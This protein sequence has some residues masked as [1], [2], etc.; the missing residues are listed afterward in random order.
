MYTIQH[1]A[2]LKHMKHFQ[3]S[4]GLIVQLTSRNKEQVTPVSNNTLT[5]TEFS[6]HVRVTMS[7]VCASSLALTTETIHVV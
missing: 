1:M 2:Q 5:G 7:G 3:G 6:L 4:L